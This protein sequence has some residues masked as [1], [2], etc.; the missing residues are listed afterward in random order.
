MPTKCVFNLRSFPTFS[1]FS[2]FLFRR[3]WGKPQLVAR[4]LE[5]RKRLTGFVLR[6]K[7]KR[8]FWKKLDLGEFFNCNTY[9]QVFFAHACYVFFVLLAYYAGFGF[10]TLSLPW[11]KRPRAKRVFVSMFKKNCAKEL[12]PSCLH[13]WRLPFFL[14][15]QKSRQKCEKGAFLTKAISK[16]NARPCCV[17]KQPQF[18]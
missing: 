14:F 7:D 3:L 10:H 6:G 5:R 1:F 15:P 4:F 16:C 11:H 2:F 13:I 18:P 8:N 17:K 9:F 12:S